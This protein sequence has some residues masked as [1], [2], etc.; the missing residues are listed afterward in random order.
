[1]PNDSLRGM[2]QP[3]DFSTL[4][5]LATGFGALLEQVQELDKRNTHLE[6]LLDRMKEQ[7]CDSQKPC[8]SLQMVG[9]DNIALDLELLQQ[10]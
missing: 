9:G 4:E 5:Q 8:Y 10:R 1:M 7:V 6:S 3:A 2:D